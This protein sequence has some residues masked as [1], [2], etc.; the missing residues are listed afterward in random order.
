MV[1]GTLDTIPSRVR[2]P[3]EELE[4]VGLEGGVEL[5]ATPRD[6]GTTFGIRAPAAEAAWVCLFDG[7]G[8]ERRVTME[9]ASV[10]RWHAEVEGVGHGQRYGFRVDGPFEPGKGHWY[11]PAKLLVDPLARAT[12]GALRWGP[13]LLPEDPP[14][15]GRRS[16]LDSA[17]SVPFGVVVDPA[18]DWGGDRALRT[19]WERTVLY[20]AHVRGLTKRHPGLP[21]AW[22][23]TY[24]ALGTPAVVEHLH[25]LGVT[26]LELLPIGQFVTE[27]AVAARGLVNYWGYNPIAPGAPNEAYAASPEPASSVRELK[28]AVAALH[29]AG[30]E[31]V[32]D[33]VL[34]H[35]AEWDRSG[36]SLSLRGLGAD[37]YFR[38]GEGGELVDWTGCH[39]TLDLS[40]PAMVELAIA[41]LRRFVVEYHVD[42][43][44]FDLGVVLGRGTD[45]TFD[46]AAPFFQAVA[47]TPELC[48]VKLIAEPWDVGPGGYCLGRFPP[49]WSEWNGR[50][51]DVVRDTWRGTPGQL[52]ELASRL[53]GSADLFGVRAASASVNFVSAHDGF[54]LADLVAYEAKHNEA[55]GEANRDGTDDNRSSNAGVEGPTDDPTILERRARRVRAMVATLLVARGVPMLLAGDELG[56]T[57]AGNNNAYCQ[58]S[59]LTW[60]DWA[61]ADEVL[62][63]DVRAWVALRSELGLLRSQAAMS[64]EE[65]QWFDADGQP[66][67]VGQWQ[68]PDLAGLQL[69]LLPVRR[70]EDVAVLVVVNRSA[71]PLRCSLAPGTWHLRRASWPVLDSGDGW[72][73]L[74]PESVAVYA[75]D[76]GAG[77]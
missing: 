65:A 77:G 2:R 69:R 26:T 49:G 59:P 37:A 63:D 25:R 34:N 12:T 11:N 61:H 73:V 43:F 67:S 50:F 17:G 48:G 58:D 45:G 27:E 8:R 21:A 56:R 38:L 66:L 29:E 41:V 36:P 44:R 15:S 75:G 18:F 52:P 9:P 22:R 53:A 31:V 6:G 47:A 76:A 42:G 23:G 62:L 64:P 5:G 7:D 72:G 57:Q 19:P 70:P 39:N 4:R 33:I 55:N 13:A 32:L 20:E 74:A 54:T 16:E 40:K 35:D 30:I 71:G 10:G 28:E 51:R 24:R 68:D 1:C 14:G 3:A 46:P 60:L